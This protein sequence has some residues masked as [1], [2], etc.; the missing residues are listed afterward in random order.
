LRFK[1]IDGDR[2]VIFGVIFAPIVAIGRQIDV[3]KD[4]PIFSGLDNPAV[5]WVE[6]GRFDAATVQSYDGLEF[7][8]IVGEIGGCNKGDFSRKRLKAGNSPFV[9]GITSIEFSRE[10]I[11]HFIK[12]LNPWVLVSSWYFSRLVQI[13][14]LSR[15]FATCGTFYLKEERKVRMAGP[16]LLDIL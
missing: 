5:A 7:A 10:H 9:F 4:L 16:E 15:L 8:G 13:M 12:R 3:L 14:P 2:V 11:L 6:G 1:F